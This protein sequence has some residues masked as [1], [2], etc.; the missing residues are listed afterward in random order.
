MAGPW[1]KYQTPDG[2]WKKYQA[3]SGPS[4]IPAPSFMSS[5]NRGIGRVGD[6]MSELVFNPIDATSQF[7][8]GPRISS[9]DTPF[10]D[11]L[12]GLGAIGGERDTGFMGRVGEGVGEAAG[13]LLPFGAAANMASKAPGMIGST[14]NMFMQPFVRNP[15]AAV[16]TELLAGGGAGAGGEVAARGFGEEYRG[17]GEVIGGLGAGFAPY[18]PA[19][20]A[21]GGAKMPLGRSVVAAIAPYSESGARTVA[22]RRVQDMVADPYAVGTQIEQADNIGNLTPGQLANDPRLMGLESAVRQAYPDVDAALRD[23]ARAS[24]ETLEQAARAPAQGA[25]PAETQAFY[26]ERQQRLTTALDARVAKAEAKA[27]E[28]LAAIGPQR[29]ETENSRIVREEIDAAYA[30]AR[31]TENRLWGEVPKEA[32]VG[33]ANVYGK[34]DEIL[35]ST[36]MAQRPDIPSEARAVLEDAWGKAGMPFDDAPGRATDQSVAEMHG[37]YSKLRETA[38]NARSGVAPQNNKARIADE[39][40][41]AI[42]VDLGALDDVPGRVGQ[43]INAARQFSREMA[44]RFEHGQ[45]GK[46]LGRLRS[47]GDAIDPDLTLGRTV[48][49]GGAEGKVAIDD[50]R[51]AVGTGANSEGAISDYMFRRFNDYA[52]PDGVVDPAKAETF[53]RN[54]REML[55]A[56]PGA[57]QQ[58]R[59]AVDMRRGAAQS[60]ETLGDARAAAGDPR[61]SP[62]AAFQQA[63]AGEEFGAV[64]KAQNPAAAAKALAAKAAR[65]TTGAATRGLKASAFDNLMAQAR[66]VGDD[67]AETLSGTRFL[68]AFTDPKTKAALSEVLSPDE[69]RRVGI[70]GR[71]LAAVERAGRTGAAADGVLPS[72]AQ[73]AI[74]FVL[75]TIGARVGAQA[76][77]GTSGAS[78][79]TASMFSGR[80]QAIF[81]SLSTSQAERLLV[82]AVQDPK[83]MAALLKDARNP[84]NAKELETRLSEWAASQSGQ[85]IGQ[86]PEQEPAAPEANPWEQFAPQKQSAIMGETSGRVADFRSE[87]PP[88]APPVD[89]KSPYQLASYFTGLDERKDAAVLSGFIRSMTGKNLDPTKTAWCAAFVNA[90]LGAS[91][92]EGT[93]ALNAR[94]FLD[95]G[96]ET[97]N[98]QRGDVAVFWRESPDSW[99]GHVGFYAGET[100]KNGQ[101]YIRVLGGNQDDS[102]SEKL[103]PASRL[104]SVRRP[105]VIRT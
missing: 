63:R 38:R 14:A 71:E 39:L 77:A 99:K 18:S 86:E 89:A 93:G 11:A 78:L 90:V 57:Q 85:M 35:R 6:A 100:T 46:L 33:T 82:D 58:I 15:A 79:R 80:V 84:R 62:A 75:G 29:S 24:V 20:L 17:T 104:L 31:E 92:H 47:G 73:S 95:F 70:I 27:Q 21:R 40:A 59:A 67:G 88:P 41:D 19:A 16:G 7:F 13:A 2:P 44:T 5:V 51:A 49:R 52:A 68:R 97:K 53:I 96:T 32:R 54:N 9:T 66:I 91:G 55:D 83:L 72:N 3:S 43:T 45:V 28:R 36:P 37:L 48:G 25:T 26:A 105:P 101:R 64:L 94:S 50:I 102:V 81:D 87:A 98:P 22:A 69:M 12:T 76:G 34:F 4:G 42:L 30:D 60:A 56:M 103:Y 10:T 23:R 8:G 65:D 61:Q 74:R 1:E